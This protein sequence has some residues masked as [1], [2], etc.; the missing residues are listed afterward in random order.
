MPSVLNQAYELV[1]VA[2]LRQHP[3]N[4]NTG[5]IGAIHQSIQA[6]GFYGAIVAQT[7]TGFV[8]AGNHRLAAAQHAGLSE[9]PVTWVDVDD[10]EALRILLVD[11]RTAELATRDD[12]AIATILQELAATPEGL[13]GTGYDGDDLDTLL[14]DLQNA[15]VY[16]NGD[17]TDPDPISADN[18][19]SKWLVNVGDEW[20][21]GGITLTV[22]DARNESSY[23]QMQGNA[24]V[25]WTDPPY[26]VNYTGK[27]KD[28]L[29]IKNDASG[30]NEL[31]DLLE[32]AFDAAFTRISPGGG[33]VCSG[34]ARAATSRVP[35]IVVH[36]WLATNADLAEA[37]PRARA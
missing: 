6:T 35:R 29:T 17:A 22:G 8:L 4:A 19:H 26:G 12:Q 18:A 32:A 23:S 10:E 7:S 16:A 13:L 3:R 11:N 31:R 30:E 37:E 28:Q 5:D 20:S 33:V 24:D 25:M 9:V 36:A 14:F 27:T 15:G 2:Q 21:G 1:P 34:R